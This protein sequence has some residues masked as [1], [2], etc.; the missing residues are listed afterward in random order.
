MKYKNLFIVSTG[1]PVLLST[2]QSGFIFTLKNF[3]EPYKRPR[4]TTFSIANIRIPLVHRKAVP[5][6]DFETESRI[7]NYMT[8]HQNHITI[9]S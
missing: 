6:V 4:I 2:V 5:L 8:K 1:I 7:V 3:T 9:M